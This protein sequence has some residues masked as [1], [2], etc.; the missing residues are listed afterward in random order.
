MVMFAQYVRHGDCFLLVYAINN[1]QSFEEVQAM[2]QWINRMRD[3]DMPMV[4]TTTHA[5]ASCIMIRSAMAISCCAWFC[6]LSL[7]FQYIHHLKIIER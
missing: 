4:R 2:H 6:K 1:R 7:V 3:Q 5:L